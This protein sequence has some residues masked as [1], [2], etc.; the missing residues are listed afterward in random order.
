M[1]MKLHTASINVFYRYDKVA[2]HCSKVAYY[3]DLVATVVTRFPIDVAKLSTTVVKLSIRFCEI[4]YNCYKDIEACHIYSGYCFPPFGICRVDVLPSKIVA[5]RS[6][7]SVPTHMATP[8]LPHSP[9][10]PIGPYKIAYCCNKIAQRCC[11]VAYY[12]CKIEH[13][14]YKSVGYQSCFV[15]IKIVLSCTKFALARGM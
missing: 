9:L 15:G 6:V 5:M 12:C 1:M 3:Y 11:E 2:Y 10:P 7:T 4:A 14:C 13:H 8:K